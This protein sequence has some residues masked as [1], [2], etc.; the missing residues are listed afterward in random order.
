MN[1]IKFF[2]TCG[3]NIHLG[4]D[5]RTFWKVLTSLYVIKIAQVKLMVVISMCDGFGMCFYFWANRS[6]TYVSRLNLSFLICMNLRHN[7][8]YRLSNGHNLLLRQ[9]YCSCFY[10][11]TMVFDTAHCKVIVTTII[12]IPRCNI[13]E[14]RVSLK[15]NYILPFY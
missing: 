2:K 7:I 13:H 9:L 3:K 15:I 4:F 8:W 6:M 11:W 14:D 5:L 1:I 12:I 10:Q